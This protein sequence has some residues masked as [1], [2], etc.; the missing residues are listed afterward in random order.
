MLK[1]NRTW[2]VKQ[3][4]NEQYNNFSYKLQYSPL[5]TFIKKVKAVTRE[6]AYQEAHSNI[7]Q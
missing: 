1:E 7:I 2:V 4:F 5:T 3:D 6:L